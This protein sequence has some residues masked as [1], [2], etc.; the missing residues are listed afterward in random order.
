ME[1]KIK[2]N[3]KERFLTL[4]ALVISL[5]VLTPLISML[6]IPLVSMSFPFL[7]AIFC[8]WYLISYTICSYTYT[9]KENYLLIEKELSYKT[10]EL[11]KIKYESIISVKEEKG[12][13]KNLTVGVFDK[14][15]LLLT[16]LDNKSEKRV[17]IHKSDDLDKQFKERLSYE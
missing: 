11:L 12:K 8:C 9:F 10:L 14:S 5:Y 3:K 2:K 13:A 17:K 15:Y 7:Y 6:G 16:Y 1:I 4:L